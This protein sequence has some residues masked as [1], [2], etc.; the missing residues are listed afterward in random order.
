M[1]VLGMITCLKY[2]TPLFPNEESLHW[3]LFS[4]SYSPS[5]PRWHSFY[6]TENDEKSYKLRLTKSLIKKTEEDG[7]F[8]Y[9]TQQSETYS[10][11]KY[12]L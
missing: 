7:N 10:V 11:D 9:I 4:T 8:L 3:S 2:S 12:T 5:F 1:K 6:P